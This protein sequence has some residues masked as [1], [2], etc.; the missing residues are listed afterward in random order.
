[1]YFTIIRPGTRKELRRHIPYTVEQTGPGEWTAR[2]SETGK[3]IGRSRVSEVH[4]RGHCNT[5]TEPK[6]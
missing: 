1:M 2:N 3:T 6:K 5:M 4:L